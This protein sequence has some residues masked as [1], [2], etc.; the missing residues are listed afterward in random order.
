MNRFVSFILIGTL[1]LFRNVSF[2]QKIDTICKAIATTNTYIPLPFYGTTSNGHIG[3]AGLNNRYSENGSP[4]P[5][6][7]VRIDLTSNS[8]SYKIIN[9]TVSSASVYWSYTFDSLGNF[10]LGLNT[11]NRK[12]FRFNFKDSIWYENL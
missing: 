5:I 11:A 3:C 8:I 7:I 1:L 2:A 6:E 10:Y 4:L 12:I 9:G